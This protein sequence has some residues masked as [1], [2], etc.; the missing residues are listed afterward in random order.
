MSNRAHLEPTKF[1]NLRAGGATYGFRIWD[2]NYQGY[3]NKLTSDDVQDDLGLLALVLK[4]LTVVPFDPVSEILHTVRDNQ[5]GI[6]V[7][8][9]YYPWEQIQHLFADEAQPG[10]SADQSGSGNQS[11]AGGSDLAGSDSPQQG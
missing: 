10:H 5:S 9:T 7:G 11:V 3:N 1:R 2:D 6:F 4:D 8:E